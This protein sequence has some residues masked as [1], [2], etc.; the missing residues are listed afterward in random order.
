MTDG[1]SLDHNYVGKTSMCRSSNAISLRCLSHPRMHPC[2]Y[3]EQ[4]P[5]RGEKKQN[6]K[7]QKKKPTL[8]AFTCS[9]TE[10]KIPQIKELWS[11][12]KSTYL[13]ELK[14]LDLAP[15]AVR[16]GGCG[17]DTYA[18]QATVSFTISSMVSCTTCNGKQGSI[19]MYVTRVLTGDVDMAYFLLVAKVW[20]GRPCDLLNTKTSACGREKIPPIYAKSRHSL[21]NTQGTHV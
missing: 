8:H 9:K 1:S 20:N 17:W 2:L 6:S 15:Y 10:Q 16:I 5:I 12:Q 3:F 21:E 13:W 14:G 18:A 11:G 7:T 4:S 19:P